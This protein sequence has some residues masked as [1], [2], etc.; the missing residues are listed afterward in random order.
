VGA[1]AVTAGL[2][3]AFFSSFLAAG[4]CAKA[5]TANTEAMRVAINFMIIF[6]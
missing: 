2:A 3:S 5:E 1:G 4:A 6:L